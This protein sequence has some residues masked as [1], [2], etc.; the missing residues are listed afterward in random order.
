LL[1][2]GRVITRPPH[3]EMR[4]P[5]AGA[6]F[7]VSMLAVTFGIA[8]WTAARHWPLARGV[9]DEP[10]TRRF[11]GATYAVRGW[12]LDPL[13]VASIGV[14]AYDDWNSV[15]PTATWKA[16]TGLRKTGPQGE[17]LERYFPTYPESANGGFAVD[18]P[19]AGLPPHATCLRTQVRN[20]LGVVTEI[21]RRCLQP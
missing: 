16:T 20:R 4:A 3:V 5:R 11:D 18:I 9:V 1:C 13:G 14:A 15:A 17:S 10:A 12:A 19:R 8:L 2:A 21:D 7:M 6:T